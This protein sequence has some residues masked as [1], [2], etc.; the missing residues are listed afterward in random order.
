MKQIQKPHGYWTKER[1]L[2][3][4]RKYKTVAEWQKNDGN[5]YQRARIKG[6]LADCKKHMRDGQGKPVVCIELK[7]I[8]L[9]IEK[10]AKYFNIS[11]SHIA[12]ALTKGHTAKGYNWRY[13]KESEI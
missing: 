12:H 10:A 2:K 9:S 7:K 1:C 11:S 8:F 6:W 3:E 13:A 4:A 5:T